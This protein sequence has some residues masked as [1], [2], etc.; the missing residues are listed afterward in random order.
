VPGAAR[1][2]QAHL[3]NFFHALKAAGPPLTE[4][5]R[6][7][8]SRYVSAFSAWGEEA[9]VERYGQLHYVVADVAGAGG[10]VRAAVLA[11]LDEAAPLPQQGV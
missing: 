10:D 8:L 3:L 5:E 7:A 1:R 9:R 11:H 2:A 6:G 4:R